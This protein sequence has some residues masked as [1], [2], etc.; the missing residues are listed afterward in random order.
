MLLLQTTKWPRGVPAA[1]IEADK[2]GQSCLQQELFPKE[3]D[4]AGKDDGEQAERSSQRQNE[5]EVLSV[6]GRIARELCR[7][8]VSRLGPTAEAAPVVVKQLGHG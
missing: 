1:P 8:R 2:T 6:A 7:W 4:G 5:E 3:E